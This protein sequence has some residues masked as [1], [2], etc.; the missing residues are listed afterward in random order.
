MSDL[1]LS[2]MTSK[3]TA[4]ISSRTI[5]EKFERSKLLEIYFARID[6]RCLDEVDSDLQELYDLELE[7]I[8][9]FLLGQHPRDTLLHKFFRIMS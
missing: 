8:K 4:I 1:S 9:A 6:G 2:E 3:S 5:L 7:D